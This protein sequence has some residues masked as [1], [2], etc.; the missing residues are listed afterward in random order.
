M[1]LRSQRYIDIDWERWEVEELAAYREAEAAEARAQ[2][3]AEEA[4]QEAEVEPVVL[5]IESVI[6]AQDLQRKFDESHPH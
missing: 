3:E 4:E 2:Q 6:V 1:S 5:A